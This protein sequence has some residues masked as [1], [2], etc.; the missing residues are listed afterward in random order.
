MKNSDKLLKMITLFNEYNR[1]MKHPGR[2]FRE[3][4][5]VIFLDLMGKTEEY[6]SEQETITEMINSVEFLKEQGTK[7]EKLVKF[8]EKNYMEE[9]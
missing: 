8:I 2:L 6:L 5:R 4:K 9:K 1:E 3:D 7:A